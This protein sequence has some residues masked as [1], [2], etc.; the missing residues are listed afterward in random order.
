ML[1]LLL[2][3]LTVLTQLGS[4]SDPISNTFRPRVLPC[5]II[6]LVSPLCIPFVSTLIMIRCNTC[7]DL[8]PPDPSLSVLFSKLEESAREAS[9][10]SCR[11]LFDAIRIREEDK[12]FIKHVFISKGQSTLTLSLWPGGSSCRNSTFEK[13]MFFHVLQD[14]YFGLISLLMPTWLKI[15]LF[16]LEDQKFWFMYFW[17]F[18]RPA[19]FMAKHKGEVIHFR[20]YRIQKSA[21][22][23]CREISNLP[24]RSLWV[25]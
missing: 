18:G 10:Q 11:L 4:E 5:W 20:W 23:S 12:T 17:H 21:L 2:R 14:I 24:Q 16:D 3:R 25:F 7:R 22:L 15:V 1:S 13:R 6:L 8:Q 19:V 9:R